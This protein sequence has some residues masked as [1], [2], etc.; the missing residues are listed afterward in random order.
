MAHDRRYDTADW[1][2]P[3][4]LTPEE[5]N[6][7]EKMGAESQIIAYLSF[8]N[9]G[10]FLNPKLEAQTGKLIAA[11][12]KGQLTL[13]QLKYIEEKLKTSLEAIVG[14]SLALLP[15]EGK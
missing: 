1:N 2:H 5:S 14:D 15:E 13:E 6:R 12:E 8:R 3:A 9:N 10:A 4:R 11:I 7:V